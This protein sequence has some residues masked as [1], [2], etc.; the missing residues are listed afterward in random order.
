[1]NRATNQK[2]W[3]HI[4]VTLCVASEIRPKYIL[5]LHN[6]KL[7]TRNTPC[8]DLSIP[9]GATNLGATW[10]THCI[11]SKIRPQY[12]LFL[13]NYKLETRNTPCIDLNIPTGTTNLGATSTTR[14]IASELRPQFIL[15][16]HNYKLVTRNTRCVDLSIPIRATDLGANSTTHCVAPGVSS[17]VRLI[18]A[19]SNCAVQNST[20]KVRGLNTSASNCQWSSASLVLL[21]SSPWRSKNVRVLPRENTSGELW[22]KCMREY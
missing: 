12:I 16:L 18:A 8:I 2:L 21:R 6:Y 11:V 1:M 7:V 22:R 14:C 5:F 10:T 15:F 13:H 17:G 4:P 9:T 19:T 20:Q 3:L